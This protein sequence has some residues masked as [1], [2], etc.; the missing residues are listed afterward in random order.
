MSYVLLDSGVPPDQKANDGIYSGYVPLHLTKAAVGQYNIQ[1]QASDNQG[2]VSNI[3]GLP[4]TVISSNNKPPIISALIA[5]DTVFVPTGST[6]N[7]ITVSVVASDADGLETIASVS[8]RVI[9]PDGT[10]SIPYPLLDDGGK[11]PDPVFTGTT[12]GDATAGD[13][14]FTLRIPVT[15]DAKRNEYRDFV[16]TAKDKS[17]A[18]S[19]SLTKRIYI[20]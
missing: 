14:R 10:I 6:P 18:I 1:I 17:G 15:F 2:L 4:V 5:P 3:I 13:G 20:Q 11:T 8:T 16:F 9:K 7:Y 19:N 12:S